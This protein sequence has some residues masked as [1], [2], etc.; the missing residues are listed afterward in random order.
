MKQSCRIFGGFSKWA[1]ILVGW[2]VPTEGLGYW[3]GI[4]TH[5][6]R[7]YDAVVAEGYIAFPCVVASSCDLANCFI[8]RNYCI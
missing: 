6:E 1:D 3:T 8:R 4:G 2:N 5:Y 7:R